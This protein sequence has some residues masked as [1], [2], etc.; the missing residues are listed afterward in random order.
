MHKTCDCP[1]ITLEIF[2]KNIFLTDVYDFVA[3]QFHKISLM[4][5]VEKN[6]ICSE[7]IQKVSIFLTTTD[8]DKLGILF[9]SNHNI[10]KSSYGLCF[11]ASDTLIERLY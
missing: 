2:D 5:F 1:L 4:G 3:M 11:W 8:A 7:W 9:L 10:H 6:I